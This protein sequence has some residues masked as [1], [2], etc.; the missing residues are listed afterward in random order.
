MPAPNLERLT[1]DPVLPD[2]VDVVI[3]GGGIAGASTAF[4]LTEKGLRVAVCEKGQVGG[5]QSSRN[6]GWVRQMGRDRAELPLAIESLNIWRD[7]EPRWGIRAGFR[8][9][10]IVYTFRSGENEEGLAGWAD[11]ANEYQLPIKRLTKGQ[12]QELM[13]GIAPDFDI[14]YHT[15]NDGRGEPGMATPAIARAAQERGA[16]ILE[17]CAVRS[18]E[19]AAGRVSGVVTERGPIKCNAVVVAGGVWSR[20]FLGNLGITFPQLKVTGGAFRVETDAVLPEMPIGGTDFSFRK[21]EDGGYTVARRNASLAIITPDSFRFFSDFLPSL[22]TS[23]RE[24]KLRVGKQ[25]VT[26]LMMP[27]RWAADAK[28]PFETFRTLDPAPRERLNA[29]ALRNTI[30]AFPAFANARVTHQWGGL[31]DTT[32]DAVP[33]IDEVPTMPGLY[34]SS[35]YSGHG[36]GIGP[37]AG[38][39]TADLINGDH[40]IVDL[41]PFKLSRL[42]KG[43]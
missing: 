39:L 42:R 13:P 27:K 8:Q 36:F 11:A 24:L 1:P 30:R 25:F 35:G 37:G 38:R 2:A 23:W 19:T 31:I 15:S 17:N 7:L 20:L 12:V 22:V 21:R 43:K 29:E 16:V 10:G 18:V 32:P 34:I 9:T 26:E 5:E 6:W 40:P 33:V 28:T 4:F 14:A 3:I 41:A